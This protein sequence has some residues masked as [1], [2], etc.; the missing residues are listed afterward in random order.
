[1]YV[2]IFS[3]S[4]R[5]IGEKLREDWIGNF[6]TISHILYT[7]FKFETTVKLYKVR[8]TYVIV[9]MYTDF[10]T[11]FVKTI[12]YRL[13]YGTIMFWR[14]SRSKTSFFLSLM[15]SLSCKKIRSVTYVSLN[16]CCNTIDSLL[17][18]QSELMLFIISLE[19]TYNTSIVYIEYYEVLLYRTRVK[20][21]L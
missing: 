15:L 2:V 4:C 7:S 8:Y 6:R 3:P 20:L 11:L 18:K 21:F 9:R 16:N 19:L 17:K 1:M 14:T 10:Y 5:K 12:C 13:K